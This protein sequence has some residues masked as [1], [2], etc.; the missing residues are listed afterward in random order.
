MTG[1]KM[2]YPRCGHIWFII[3]IG[4]IFL[5]ACASTNST[6][7]LYGGSE[8]PD[9][10]IVKIRVPYELEV[11]SIDGRKLKTPYVP[12]GEY[13]LELLPGKHVFKVIYTEYWGDETSGNIEVSDA[14]YFQVATTAGSHYVFKHN[15]PADLVYASFNWSISDIKIWLVQQETG[16]TI[17]AASTSTYGNYLTRT[18]RQAAS[19]T[20]EDKPVTDSNTAQKNNT[21][22]TSPT[23][24]KL[25]AKPDDSSALIAEQIIAQQNALDRLK[26]WWKMA[27]ENQRKAFQAWTGKPVIKSGQE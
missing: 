25:T 16:Q 6:V 8:K 11:L 7:R 20:E 10:E 9:S 27:D 24:L 14:F 2:L 12:D 13:L 1:I 15:G 23:T 3:I 17:N 21:K 18:L 5:S 22:M 4:G 19:G 26:F